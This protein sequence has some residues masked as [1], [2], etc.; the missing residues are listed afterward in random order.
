[1]NSDFAAD[2][3]LLAYP[4]VQPKGTALTQELDPLRNTTEYIGFDDSSPAF[5]DID[6]AYLQWDPE[7]PWWL[8]VAVRLKTMSGQHPWFSFGG[9][10]LRQNGTDIEFVTDDGTSY[11]VP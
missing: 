11:K 4:I 9:N 5:L 6:N 7:R 10:T 8:G 2:D 1:P 3:S